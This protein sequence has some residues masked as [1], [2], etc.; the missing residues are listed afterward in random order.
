MHASGDHPFHTAAKKDGSFDLLTVIP[1]AFHL[2]SA[3]VR[4][5]IRAAQRPSHHLRFQPGGADLRGT[6]MRTATLKAT[7]SGRQESLLRAGDRGDGPLGNDDGV[8]FGCGPWTY[9]QPPLRTAREAVPH[10]PHLNC[11]SVYDPCANQQPLFAF[12]KHPHDAASLPL[13]SFLPIQAHRAHSGP[14][15]TRSTRRSHPPRPLSPRLPFPRPFFDR[16]PRAP[17]GGAH[18]M[19]RSAPATGPCPAPFRADPRRHSRPTAAT[20]TTT[21]YAALQSPW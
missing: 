20:T 2:A 18:V 13:F 16:S 19:H 1:T 21:D 3:R 8:S 11:K 15:P 7:G 4:L 6:R 14:T 12:H 9:T 17:H 5:C 10:P